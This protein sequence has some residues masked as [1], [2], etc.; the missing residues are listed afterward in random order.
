MTEQTEALPAGTRD[1]RRPAALACNLLIVAME[2]AG[3]VLSWRRNGPGMFVFYTEDSN[4]LALFA[5]AAYAVCLLR[6]G[7]RGKPVPVWASVL[8]YTAASC[9]TLTFLVVVCVLAPQYG[10][11]QGYAVMLFR[12]SM[13]FTH[14]LCPVLA[15]LSFLLLD[16]DG[17][18]GRGAL[19]WAAVPTVVYAAVTIVLNL[20]GVLRGPYPFLL[21]YEQPWWASVLWGA[22]IVGGAALLALLLARL[23]VRLRRGKAAP[24]SCNVPRPMV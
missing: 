7:S 9:L 4:L 5:C 12:D 15:V 17:G 24:P 10:F 14:F 11:P 8:K 2:L 1:R 23:R 18:P 22:G 16:P 21:V 19:R 20:C 13:L 3:A 6:A